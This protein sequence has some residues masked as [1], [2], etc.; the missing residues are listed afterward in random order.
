MDVIKK[1]TV[2]SISDEGGRLTFRQNG[3]DDICNVSPTKKEPIMQKCPPRLGPFLCLVK[4]R[5][6]GKFSTSP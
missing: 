2:V 3:S 4:S 5:L 6:V 1:T